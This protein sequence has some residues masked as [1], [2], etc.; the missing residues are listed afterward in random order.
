PNVTSGPLAASLR[1]VTRSVVP[2]VSLSR[3]SLRTGG[4]G[5]GPT[6]V[7]TEAVSSD[8]SPSGTASAETV[9]V[10]VNVPEDCGRRWNWRRLNWLAGTVVRQVIVPGP[11]SQAH[12]P[13]SNVGAESGGTVTV[14]V[15]AIG[16]PPALA[17]WAV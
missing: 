3:P 10:T 5:S 9:P 16:N 12:G 17:T 14:S 6:V 2:M 8:G 7:V 1:A 4:P 11:V 15:A 13:R